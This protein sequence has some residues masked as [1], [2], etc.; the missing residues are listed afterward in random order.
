MLATK[1]PDSEKLKTNRF[2]I[3]CIRLVIVKISNTTARSLN[4]GTVKRLIW[5]ADAAVVGIVVQ[6][7][8]VFVSCSSWC[9]KCIKDVWKLSFIIKP[10]FVAILITS[11]FFLVVIVLLILIVLLPETKY[12]LNI[13]VSKQVHKGTSK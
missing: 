5:S 6:L 9:W 7:L 3:K 12:I 4:N 8:C 2:T 11:Q 1:I 10:S 13:E